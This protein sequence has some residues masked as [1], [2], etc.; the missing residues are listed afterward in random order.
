MSPCDETFWQAIDNLEA[1]G[2]VA[3]FACGNEGPDAATI[4]NPADRA[5]GPG[6]AF[7][8]GAVDQTLLD[9][10]VAEFS[11]RGP[12]N[13]ADGDIK[14]EIVAP[15]VAIRSS[16]KGGGYKT[17]SGTSMAAPLVAGAIAL[18]REYNPDATVEQIKNALLASAR[19]LGPVG[20]DNDYGWGMIDVAAA[21]EYLPLPSK[22][23]LELS[24]ISVGSGAFDIL[25]SGATS[26]I[27]IVL[28]NRNM[29]ADDLWARLQSANEEVLVLQDS[30]YFGSATNGGQV[31]AG[32]DAFWVKLD[33][34]LS[35]GTPLDFTLNV[36]SENLGFLNALEFTLVSDQPAEAAVL[37]AA[38]RRLSVTLSNFGLTRNLTAEILDREV[39]SGLSLLV[40]D[41]LGNV[42]D[43]VPGDLDW[44]ATEE[45]QS[46]Q[47]GDLWEGQ[48]AFISVDGSLEV[49]QTAL[50]GLESGFES[51]LILEYE[52]RSLLAAPGAELQVGVAIDLDLDGGESLFYSGSEWLAR[53]AGGQTQIGVRCLLSDADAI[54]LSGELYKSGAATEADKLEWLTTAPAGL[55]GLTGD[56]VLM[57]RIPQAGAGH[58]EPLRFARVSAVGNTGLGIDL[59]LQQGTERYLTSTGVRDRIRLTERR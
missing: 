19:D 50:I 46:W 28:T 3:V 11:S 20:E 7:S 15:G 39:L 54:S 26:A 52:I 56:Q 30:V 6:N 32:E 8:V 49:T 55:S 13:C 23:H 17:I 1:L 9:L 37:I 27:G 24:D 22:P 47:S 43:A 41:E 29:P 21:L 5:S 33:H 34:L 45:L 31:T 4:R 2:V 44:L 57:L 25:A 53:T 40:A 38:N 58:T 51:Y 12:G 10:P 48:G 59:A 36:Y 16:Y 42:F 18:L 14:P 35:P